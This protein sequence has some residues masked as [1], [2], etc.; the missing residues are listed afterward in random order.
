MKSESQLALPQAQPSTAQL[1]GAVIDR[2][3]TA[4]SVNVVERLVA[5][6]RDEQAHEAEREFVRDFVA[7]QADIPAM[8]ASKAVKNNDGTHRY[9]FAPFEEIMKEVKPLLHR[10]NFA[11]TFDNET[12]DGR[13]IVTCTLMHVSGHS[14]KNR[15]GARIG[16]GPP[17]SS[18]AQAEGAASS[19]A[20]RFALC[21]AL[22]I[23]IE[24][25]TDAR[26]VSDNITAEEAEELQ[27]GVEETGIDAPKFLAW[28]K[29][30]EFTNIPSN[31]LEEA[32]EQIKK[33][34]K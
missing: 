31:R 22:N 18:E 32:R 20:K 23:T 1:I 34:R 10:H 17:G 30:S 19:Y 13:V 8:E 15:H 4:D 2:G 5:L 26:D 14:R 3:I 9:N 28:L 6:R 27:A 11:V 24:T 16:K 25:D 12:V 29:A 7:L 21:S 33:R